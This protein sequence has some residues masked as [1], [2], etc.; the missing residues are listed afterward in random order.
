MTTKELFVKYHWRQTLFLGVLAVLV[1]GFQVFTEELKN[2][3]SNLGM[4]KSATIEEAKN[5]STDVQSLVYQEK[6]KTL[7][8][9]YLS[10]RAKY[11]KPHEGWLFLINNTRFELLK[12]EVPRVYQ[13]LHL[14][15]ATTLDKEKEAL[16]GKNEANL[17]LTNAL[18][19][20]ILEQYFW[21]N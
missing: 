6:V 7:V 3:A 17:N 4:V 18:W 15:L 13:E 5:E 2:K 14:A 19:E 8:I 9:N 11:A 21:L 1:I 12:M 20:K 10:E 16:M